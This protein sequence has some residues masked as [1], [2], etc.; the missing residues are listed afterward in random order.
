MKKTMTRVFLLMLVL[1][2]TF[3]MV[4]CGEEPTTT[5]PAEE[6]FDFSQFPAKFEDWTMAELKV[7]LREAGILVEDSWT[8][9]MSANELAAMGAAAGSLY[10]DMTAGTISDMFF[11]Y[12]S[13]AE[14]AE[15]VLKGIRDSKSIMGAIALDAMLGE[16]CISYGNTVD[17]EHRAALIQA[18]K[19]LAEHYEVTFDFITE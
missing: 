1:A 18:L 19:D 15:E 6:G 14:G 5:P 8:V 12:D 11:Y 9:D 4:A 13:T 17:E 10:V 3:S 7:Y 2:M 16:F